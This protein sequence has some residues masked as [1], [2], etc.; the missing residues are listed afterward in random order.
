MKDPEIETVRGASGRSRFIG[1]PQ[2]KVVPSSAEAPRPGNGRETLSESVAEWVRVRAFWSF[3]TQGVSEIA[4]R[5]SDE[6]FRGLPG[7][8]VPLRRPSTRSAVV[9][10]SAEA[11]DS[12]YLSG[13]WSSWPLCAG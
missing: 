5:K 4:L 3:P 9:V 13:E 11:A 8:H 7:R 2:S 10:H 12:T 6:V 1:C